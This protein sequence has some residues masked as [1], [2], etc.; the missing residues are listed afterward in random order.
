MLIFFVNEAIGLVVIA[1]THL[2]VCKVTAGL[3]TANSSTIG[4]Q[5]V[6][7]TVLDDKPKNLLLE[8]ILL[9]NFVTTTR[10]ESSRVSIH[11]EHPHKSIMT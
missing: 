9:Q 8:A 7:I 5:L 6:P 4:C 11:T 1:E 10:Q 2:G 3:Q